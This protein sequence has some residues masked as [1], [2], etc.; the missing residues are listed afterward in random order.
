M[1]PNDKKEIDRLQEE[2]NQLKSDVSDGIGL[3]VAHA[4]DE[5]GTNME[6]IE[7]NL[8]EMG[9]N[10]EEIGTNLENVGTNLEEVGANLEGIEANLEDVGTNLGDIG[11]NLE[12]LE[13][14]EERRRNLEAL[15]A[16]KS[17]LKSYLLRLSNV[18]ERTWTRCPGQLRRF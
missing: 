5:I 9:A 11:T 6:E 17:L 8:E 7:T 12:G 14:S 15:L 1:K 13:K 4:V 3:H 2:L 18:W 16:S 10:L